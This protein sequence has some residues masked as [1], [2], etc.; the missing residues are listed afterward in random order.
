VFTTSIIVRYA[1]HSI[2]TL[3]LLKGHCK[4]ALN[5]FTPLY[6]CLVEVAAAPDHGPP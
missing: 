6:G 1:L 5:I 4:W 3:G 2:A